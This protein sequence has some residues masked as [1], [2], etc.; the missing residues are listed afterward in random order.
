[1]ILWLASYPKSGNTLIRSLLSSYFFSDSGDFK[2]EL[3][4]NIKQFPKKIFF[5]NLG[6][7]LKDNAELA[8]N[9]IN[10][11]KIINKSGKFQF[12]KT[13][14]SFC[15]INNKYSFS[16]LN[17]SLGVIYIVRDPRNIVSSLAHH[18]NISKNETLKLILENHFIF[19]DKDK[20][21]VYTGSWSFNYNS[22]KV[23]KNYKK[24][25][26]IR[27]EDLVKNKELN[28]KIILKF[29]KKLS[30]FQF[31]I[32]ESKI[33]KVVDTTDFYNM[34]RLED[35]EGFIEAKKDI[36]GNKIKFFNLGEK[37]QWEKYLEPEIRM[38]IE[39]GCK[40][41]MRELGYL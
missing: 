29:V 6:V 24:Y 32:D 1:M 33:K 19:D 36:K 27:Y 22:W 38:K 41:D 11:Q 2:F 31:N 14:S 28:L 35:K 26:L 13:H 20:I 40:D 8:K 37:N 39:E 16:D 17:N 30:N 5:T 34:Q 21:P 9:Y 18:N 12:W 25:L 10:A 4:N 7:D 3:L 23:F 15:K